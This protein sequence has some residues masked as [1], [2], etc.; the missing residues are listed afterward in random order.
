MNKLIMVILCI[1]I[2]CISFAQSL[3]T[4][5]EVKLQIINQ[6]TTSEGKLLKGLAS[7]V[8]VINHSNKDVY[9]P[10]FNVIDVHIYDNSFS[11]W[12]ELDLDAHYSHNGIDDP[13]PYLDEFDPKK[14]LYDVR[15]NDITKYY[16]EYIK[17][18][19]WSQ[20]GIY[21]TYLGSK[22]TRR[23]WGKH[24]F[25]KANQEVD[26]IQVFPIDRL[27][28][29]KTDYKI[30]FNT[31]SRDAAMFDATKSI[32]Y[33]PCPSSIMGYQIYMPNKLVCSPIYYSTQTTI[34][35]VVP[36]NTITP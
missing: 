30:T 21:E 29:K 31:E 15:D 24:L 28:T 35:P 4:S 9:V 32:F 7:S 8:S 17:S 23:L 20:K 13:I 36:N 25:L 14:T 11:S 18:F 5:V 33:P 2:R 34:M 1:S 10:S 19:D 3:D 27:L 16:L 12:R 22:Q 6:M 26:N